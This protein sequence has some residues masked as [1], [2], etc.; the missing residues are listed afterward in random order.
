MYQ[1]SNNRIKTTTENP[2]GRAPRICIP[3]AGFDRIERAGQVGLTDDLRVEIEDVLNCYV[4]RSGWDRSARPS[5]E[6]KIHLKLLNK[7]VKDLVNA[8][9]AYSRSVQGVLQAL[10][11]VNQKFDG[12]TDYH[13]V[14]ALEKQTVLHH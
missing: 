12:D 10:D 5:E 8:R 1:A 2:T 11:D 13:P 9:E 14:V 7:Q 4:V 3:S 6:K